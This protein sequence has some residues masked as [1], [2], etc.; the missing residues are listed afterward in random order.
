MKSM[1]AVKSV[2]SVSRRLGSGMMKIAGGTPDEFRY[3]TNNLEC[4]NCIFD[5]EHTRDVRSVFL[6][7][8][9]PIIEN[10]ES[11][12]ALRY[13]DYGGRIGSNVSPKIAASY[14]LIED[15][16]IRAS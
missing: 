12:I 11:Q 2:K 7:L 15:L 5:F 8:S 16:L 14:R 6:E 4:S 9:L 3:S 10:L 1:K 13:E